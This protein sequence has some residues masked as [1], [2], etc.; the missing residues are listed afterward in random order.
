MD[1]DELALLGMYFQFCHCT[2]VLLDLG[3]SLC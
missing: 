2:R 1:T 3:H